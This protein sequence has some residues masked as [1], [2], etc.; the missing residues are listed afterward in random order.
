MTLLDFIGYYAIARYIYDVGKALVE[1]VLRG[2][3]E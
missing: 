2:D 3:K 1:L